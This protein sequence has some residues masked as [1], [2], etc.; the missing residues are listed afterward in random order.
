MSSEPGTGS[1]L[2]A[3]AASKPNGRFLELGTGAGVGT[4]WPLAG[5]DPGSRLIS[6]DNDAEVSKIGPS[7]T[8]PAFPYSLRIW[9]GDEALSRRNW[10]GDR[11]L[12]CSCERMP[13]QEGC[14]ERR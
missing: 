1:L 10:P 3:L 6:I 12:W 14:S 9:C 8:R 4:A 13:A 11:G 7:D 2:R 5:M